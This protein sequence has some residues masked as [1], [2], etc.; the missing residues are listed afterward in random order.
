MCFHGT[1]FYWFCNKTFLVIVYFYVFVL[2]DVNIEHFGVLLCRLLMCRSI[3]H[4]CCLCNDTDLSETLGPPIQSPLHTSCR[5]CFNYPHVLKVLPISIGFSEAAKVVWLFLLYSPH[6]ASVNLV[7]HAPPDTQTIFTC[8]GS[9]LFVTTRN[10][11]W[12]WIRAQLHE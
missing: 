1:E 6:K 7:T 11:T 3:K 8:S 12:K 10:T 4:C 2:I 9:L 5:S